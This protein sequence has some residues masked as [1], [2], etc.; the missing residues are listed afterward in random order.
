MKNV[1]LSSESHS[2]SRRGCT[3]VVNSKLDFSF[4]N[5]APA[6]TVAVKGDMI[7]QIPEKDRGSIS[8]WTKK[9]NYSDY[10]KAAM[11]GSD[12]YIAYYTLAHVLSI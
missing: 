5:T 3:L 1:T 12:Y 6:G 2:A 8:N 11:K 4:I 10:N 7:L 9:H